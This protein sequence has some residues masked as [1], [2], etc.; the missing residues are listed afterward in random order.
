M[1]YWIGIKIN[2]TTVD[3]KLV[4]DHSRLMSMSSAE[5]VPRFLSGGFNTKNAKRQYRKEK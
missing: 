1:I 4:I 3:V 2:I 5:V